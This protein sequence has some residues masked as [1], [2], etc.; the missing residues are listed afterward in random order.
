M[1]TV[2][3]RHALH[4]PSLLALCFSTTMALSP[5]AQFPY[6]P[7]AWT[8]GRL[9]Y[10]PSHRLHLA[11]LPTPLY[12]LESEHPL[13]DILH[14]IDASLYIKSDD[15]SGGVELGGNKIRKLEFLLSDALLEH[16]SVVT[17]G[18]LQSNHCR[19]TAAAARMVGLEPHL[20]LRTRQQQE[21]GAVGNVLVDRLVGASIYT[22]T[23]GEYG[24]LGS[25]ELVARVCQNLRDQGRKP[26]PIPVGG[27]NG[28]GTWGYVQG[29][30]ELLEQW[31]SEKTLDHVVFACGSGGTAAGITLGM[32]LAHDDKSPTIH[33]VGVCDDPDYFYRTVAGIA[34]EMGVSLPDDASTESFIRDHMNVLQGKGKGYAVSTPEELEFCARFARATGV[35]LDPV[36]SGKA[37]YNFYLLVKEDPEAFRG[38]NIVFWH[39]GGALGMYD[40]VDALDPFLRDQSPCQRLDVYG[41]G[42]GLDISEST[43]KDGDV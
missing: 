31:P 11:T 9:L 15:R 14:S 22:C 43:T 32:A 6:D 23:P 3:S 30:D 28:L 40:K 24:R 19:A 5:T 8:K 26:Y 42:I 16:C 12:R 36:Y 10:P 20:I 34:D 38:Q 1:A 25:Q 27:S 39:T 2:R 13:L 29:V 7:P 37:L 21:I 35:V 17:I 33:A 18:G 4:R 41:K